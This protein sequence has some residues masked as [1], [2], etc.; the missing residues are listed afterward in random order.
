MWPSSFFAKSSMPIFGSVAL[1]LLIARLLPG[2]GRGQPY[3][4]PLRATPR[5]ATGWIYCR[6]GGPVAFAMA[7]ERPVDA[8]PVK[9]A[10]EVRRI[11]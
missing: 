6:P 2:R 9:P 10:A 11:G 4:G 3:R 8:A 7:F 1:Y 5:R